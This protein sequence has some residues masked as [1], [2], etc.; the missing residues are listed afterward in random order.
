MITNMGDFMSSMLKQKSMLCPRER[1]RERD[2]VQV[3]DLM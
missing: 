2:L 1:D 3:M